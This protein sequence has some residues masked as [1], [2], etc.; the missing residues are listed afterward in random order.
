[1]R[2]NV[3]VTGSRFDAGN[4]GGWA[5]VPAAKPAVDYTGPNHR[6]RPPHHQ[7]P[8]QSG[9]SVELV[10]LA[11]RRWATVVDHWSRTDDDIPMRA[12]CDRF[13]AWMEKTDETLVSK[14]L[15]ELG[16]QQLRPQKKGNASL[17]LSQIPSKVAPG[18]L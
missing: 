4:N 12:F 11:R 2:P 7:Q 6:L 16:K 17:F 14:V 8:A 18:P 1:M 13:Q 10:R 5:Q 9:K 3:P 15:L